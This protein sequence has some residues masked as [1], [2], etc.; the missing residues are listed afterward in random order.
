MSHLTHK[1][2]RVREVQ[3]PRRR[4]RRVLSDDDV[5]LVAR[6]KFAALTENDHESDEEPLI[7][8]TDQRSGQDEANTIPAR[9][10]LRSQDETTIS[11]SSR[12]VAAHLMEVRPSTL[13][14][15]DVDHQE[16]DMTLQ[17]ADTR[18][19]RSQV[20]QKSTNSPTVT[21]RGAAT[22]VIGVSSCSGVNVFHRWSIGK[23]ELHLR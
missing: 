13:I 11:A 4:R 16:F 10:G 15:E 12:A 19:W 17:D 20:Q 3:F 21:S 23:S 5:P 18:V 22:K 8:P 9:L 6:G 2:S 1:S 7:R 14:D